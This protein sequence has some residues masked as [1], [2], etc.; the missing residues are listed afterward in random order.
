MDHGTVGGVAEHLRP[1]TRVGGTQR[2]WKT[3]ISVAGK[4]KVLHKMA[5]SVVSG[6]GEE[7]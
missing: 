6:L 3:K 5:W 7:W 1:I 2:T 4:K